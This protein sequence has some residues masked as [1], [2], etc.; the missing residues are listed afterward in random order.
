MG[1]LMPQT[2]GSPR[3]LGMINRGVHLLWSEG[4]AQVG[5]TLAKYWI[6]N[7]STGIVNTLEQSHSPTSPLAKLRAHV[8]H[9][10]LVGDNRATFLSRRSAQF[11]IRLALIRPLL[12][13][14]TLCPSRAAS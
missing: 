9:I 8:V 14:G 4:R 5:L 13:P 11:S 2:S 12:R 6:I 3:N 7:L 10:Y 1:D